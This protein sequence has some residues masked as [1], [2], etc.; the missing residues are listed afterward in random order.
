MCLAVPGRVLSLTEGDFM[1]R[2]GEVQFG[3]IVKEVNLAFTP[4]AK[5]GD[6]VMVHVGFAI[7]VLAE[8]EAKE[9][10]ETLEEIGAL[11]E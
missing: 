4:E 6:Y 2:K 3:G 5:V 7:S 10:L 8:K 1:N 11:E 9:I